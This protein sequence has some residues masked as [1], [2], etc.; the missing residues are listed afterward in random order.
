M[1]IFDAKSSFKLGPT[2]ISERF[3]RK[4]FFDR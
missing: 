3:E 1:S 2:D 4:D